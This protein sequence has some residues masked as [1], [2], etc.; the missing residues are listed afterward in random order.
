[1]STVT[2]EELVTKIRG[3]IDV[4]DNMLLLWQ[5]NQGLISKIARIYSGYEEIDDL[6][7]QGYI[8]LCNAVEGYRIE[9]GA[10]FSTYAVFW[11]KQSMRR[12]IDN[13]GSI[14]RLPVHAR[15]SVMKYRERA[16]AFRLE[17]GREPNTEEIRL[18]M[19]G[20][21]WQ[22]MEQLKRDSLILDAGSL[23]SPIGEEGENTL[24]D[25]LGSDTDMETEIVE[26][27]YLKQLKAEIWPI[28]DSLPGVQGEVLRR[29]FQGGETLNEVGEAIGANRE[30][31]R[32]IESKAIRNLRSS[33]YRVKLRSFLPD[34]LE[35]MAYR[36]GLNSFRYTWTSSTERTAFHLAGSD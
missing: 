7:Q 33:S 2:N 30:R 28:V 16:A 10:S 9:E 15:N 3:G 13:S 36:S 21:T 5:Q 27:F 34:Q 25:T 1:M 24:L 32:Q 14:I 35:S 20:M 31:V 8:G 18:F 22:Q 17:Y 29:R 19:D 6:K 4:A 12:Y 11:I 26:E 23:D